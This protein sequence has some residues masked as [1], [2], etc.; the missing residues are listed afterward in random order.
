[1]R[2][3]QQ[4]NTTRTHVKM[5]ANAGA[6][7]APPPAAADVEVPE[8]LTE[9]EKALLQSAFNAAADSHKKYV[10]L[11]ESLAARHK[12]VP[13]V[14]PDNKCALGQQVYTWLE[15][16]W[17]VRLEMISGT[18]EAHYEV[19]TPELIAKK[20]KDYASKMTFNIA[21]YVSASYRVSPRR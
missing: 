20:S 17:K 8:Q 1:M 9:G 2:N 7:H 4:N 14:F 21:K 3:A 5:A 13:E 12:F 19:Y 11:A 15:L 16:R 6:G 18:A 10:L